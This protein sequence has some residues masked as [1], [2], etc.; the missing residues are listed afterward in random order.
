VVNGISQE[1]N[2][3]DTFDYGDDSELVVKPMPKN[4]PT[5]SPLVTCTEQPL[6]APKES[7]GAVKTPIMPTPLPVVGVLIDDSLQKP[8]VLPYTEKPKLRTK[9][10]AKI[11]RILWAC[12][13][14]LVIV[15][16]VAIML[17]QLHR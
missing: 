13:G 11:Q 6:D 5:E 9:S 15:L 1:E 2:D 14:V 12:F 3:N 17:N 16:I 8:S 7:L 10:G 4:A